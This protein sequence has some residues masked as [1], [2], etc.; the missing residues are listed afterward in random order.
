MTGVAELPGEQEVRSI[1]AF[2][3]R[4]PSSSCGR[5]SALQY[6]PA[7]RGGLRRRVQLQ[8]ETVGQSGEIVENAD[9]MGHF[10]T[11]LIVKSQ[12]AEGLPI[13][14]DHLRGRGAQLLGQGA[15]RVLPW[16]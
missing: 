5:R 13:C 16:G 11:G 2:R 7:F 1:P 9:N 3:D 6:Y 8:P 14:L 15:E 12:I 10:Q 4:L